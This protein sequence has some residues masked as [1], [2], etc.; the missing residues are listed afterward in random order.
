MFSRAEQSK[1]PLEK[2]FIS[3]FEFLSN[4]VTHRQLIVKLAVRQIY[5]RFIGSILGVFW[6]VVHPILL[7]AVFTFVFSI[8]LQVRWG[9]EVE[10]KASFALIL[11]SGLLLFNL[12]AHCLST[13]PSLMLSNASY[14]KKVVFPIEVLPWVVLIEGLF[15]AFVGFL[16]FLCMYL[17]VLG[18]PPLSAVTLPL[19]LVPFLLFQM[20]AMWF[21]SS[22]GV[23]VRDLSQAISILVLMLMFLS[24]L[25]YPIE[26]VPERFRIVIHLS[27]MTVVLGQVRGLLF[28]GN[29]PDWRLLVGA[30]VV[31]WGI[32]WFGYSWFRMTQ[33][34]FSDVV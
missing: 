30:F 31:T 7:L 1:T 2:R 14:I 15:H 20:G 34:G 25:F 32:A 33:R 13:A 17:F 12:L 28:W 19:V 21:L 18:V 9:V 4:A 16:V 10:N 3:P 29:W 23:Y 27:P 8:V 5:S 26:A 22:V 24:P 11:F 6:A